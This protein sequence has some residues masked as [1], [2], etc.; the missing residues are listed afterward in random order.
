MGVAA[1]NRTRVR[2]S[3]L[4]RSTGVV[5]VLLPLTHPEDGDGDFGALAFV[6]RFLDGI[7]AVATASFEAPDAAQQPACLVAGSRG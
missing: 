1:G 4:L 5:L 2:T 7:A 3:I 6:S